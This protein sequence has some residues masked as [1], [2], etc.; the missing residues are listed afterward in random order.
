[1]EK[2]LWRETNLYTSDNTGSRFSKSLANV[3]YQADSAYFSD[4]FVDVFKVAS[5]NGTYFANYHNKS[6]TA[7]HD[8]DI[9]VTA[10]TYNYG[11]HWLPL[12]VPEG[13]RN[14]P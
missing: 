5:S 14:G 8:H 3:N 10:I 6:A 1:V 11:A 2:S 13:S 12:S 4:S 9:V 7:T